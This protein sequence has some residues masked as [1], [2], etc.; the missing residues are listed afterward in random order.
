MHST[1]KMNENKLKAGKFH[2]VYATQLK[3]QNDVGFPFENVFFFK[4]F[5]A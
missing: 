1:K 4:Y 5:I 2:S 3:L